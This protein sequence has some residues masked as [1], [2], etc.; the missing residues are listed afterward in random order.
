VADS[1]LRAAYDE[2][3]ADVGYFLGFG[4]TPA[5][6]NARQQADVDYVMRAGM[7]QFYFAGF[8]WS[9]LKPV[10]DVFLHAQ[11]SIAA[12]PGDYA[13]MDSPITIS[14]SSSSSFYSPLVLGP[15]QAVYENERRMPDTFGI[16][17]CV[18][19][20]VTKGTTPD[21]QR[22]QLHFWPGA[23]AEYTLTFQYRLN[24]DALSGAIPV[25][26][27]GA[28]HSQ[29][30]LASCRAAAERDIDGVPQGSPAAVHQPAFA[31]MLEESK[32]MDRRNKAMTVGYNRDRSDWKRRRFPGT[33]PRPLLPITVQGVLYD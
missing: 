24:P 11:S 2:L 26:Y 33:T 18:C 15:W 17:I 6:W 5:D 3:R 7:R 4:R 9:F 19:E 30:L 31:Q 29:T 20:E 14:V 16:P 22:M 12:L 21:G 28:Q 1:T 32:Q 25:A 13:A 27:G 10:A 8:S 23:D